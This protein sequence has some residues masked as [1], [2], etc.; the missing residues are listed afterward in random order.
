MAAT[1]EQIARYLDRLDWR[2]EV[3]EAKSRIFTGVQAEHVEPFAIII[4]LQENGEFLRLCAPRVL[5]GVGEHEYRELI[6]RALLSLSW[7]TKMLQ[8]E[9]DLAD[10]EVRAAIELPLA[11]APLTEKQFFRCLNCLVQ[12][13]DEV[14]MPRIKQVMA[15][16]IDPGELE[17]G[18]R[19]LLML[20]E[21]AP[22][23]FLNLL[24]SALAVRQTRGKLAST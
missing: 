13:V 21:T 8:W 24:S 12:L 5:S 4:Q 20:Q 7:R 10:G 15:T 6:F 16:G 1:L 11:D 19:L 2:Y 9:Y 23:G 17:L 3:N 22:Q 18:E 14:A